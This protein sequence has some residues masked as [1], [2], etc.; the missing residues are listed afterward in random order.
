MNKNNI[1]LIKKLIIFL[2]IRTN[3]NCILNEKRKKEKTELDKLW[4][5]Y[6]QY[7]TTRQYQQ[8]LFFYA[9]GP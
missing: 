6:S 5:I 7:W 4:T 8:Y 2:D 1:Y 3:R 9:C